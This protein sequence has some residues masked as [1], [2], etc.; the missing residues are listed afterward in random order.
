MSARLE[1][2][3]ER[4]ESGSWG[5]ASCGI[6]A[7]KL[8]LHQIASA[9]CIS[10]CNTSAATSHLALLTATTRR[11]NPTCGSSDFRTVW[12]FTPGSSTTQSTRS[13]GRQCRSS[14][15]VR[16]RETPK[17]LSLRSIKIWAGVSMM[18]QHRRRNPKAEHRISRH[19]WNNYWVSDRLNLASLLSLGSTCYWLVYLCHNATKHS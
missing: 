1:S 13:E 14:D 3:T 17:L 18:K 10:R 6:G 12:I 8:A 11:I 4:L 16:R 15:P 5:F 9:P 19:S 2:D 7:D